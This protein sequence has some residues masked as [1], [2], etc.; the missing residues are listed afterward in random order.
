MLPTGSRLESKDHR[1]STGQPARW[2]R[3]ESLGPGEGGWG[4]SQT[5]TAT[6]GRLTSKLQ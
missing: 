4:G 5:K 2:A 3:R 6:S 1:L